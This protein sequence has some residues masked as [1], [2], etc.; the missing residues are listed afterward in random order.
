MKT[1]DY[2]SLVRDVSFE[3]LEQQG[4]LQLKASGYSMFPLFIPG[5]IITLNNIIQ[6]LK[7]GDIIAFKSKNRWIAHRIVSIDEQQQQL[8]TQGD[9]CAKEDAPIVITDVI[10]VVSAYYRN[11]KNMSE[12]L[13]KSGVPDET[14]KR[15]IAQKLNSLQRKKH[16]KKLLS[17]ISS[18]LKLIYKG[19]E[20]RLRFTAFLTLIIGALPLAGLY[21]SKFLINTLPDKSGESL[22]NETI[23]LLLI[24]SGIIIFLLLLQS[25]LSLVNQL[26]REKL[27]QSI[28]LHI[29]EIMHE[30]FA[31]INY[32]HIENTKEQN[33]IHRAVQESGYRPGKINDHFLLLIQSS[34]SWLLIA[35]ILI[36]IHWLI[37]VV[38]FI[39]LMPLLFSRLAHSKQQ[40]T[41]SVKE[42]KNEREIYYYHRIVTSLGFAKELRLFGMKD[43]FI[44]RF[45]NIQGSVFQRKNLLLKKQAVQEIFLQLASG[46]FVALA[47]FIAVYLTVIGKI[48]LGSFIVF[49]LL[50]QRGFA[51]LRDWLYSLAGIAEN[52]LYMK[53]FSAFL[54]LSGEEKNITV[55]E[56]ISDTAIKAQDVSFSYPGS[57]RKALNHISFEIPK[58]KKVAFVGTNGS[59]KTT[60]I[61]LICGFYNP[62]KG[63]IA[64]ND[65]IV[66]TSI[67]KEIQKQISVVFQDFALYNISARENIFLGKSTEKEVVDEIIEAAKKAGIHD[68]FEKLP[69]GYETLLGNLFEKSEELSIGQWQKIAIARALYRNAPVVLLDE[70][71]SAL[72]PFTE[73][74][75][76]ESLKT[77]AEQSTVIIVSHRLS[78]IK[79]TDCIYVFDDGRIVEQG[80]HEKLMANRGTYFQM[81]Q[82]QTE[83]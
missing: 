37:F 62:S 2:D 4:S 46:I 21:I 50:F 15:K 29:A 71:S 83:P 12:L 36:S 72:D 73:K 61:K 14:Q 1:N 17:G 13:V 78:S 28:R 59:G 3:M 67:S 8:I 54:N 45:K 57:I 31:T 76:L 38:L 64:V 53:D 5:D 60:L 24:I 68:V 79:W 80:T 69:Q 40:Y 33:L 47:F 6:P 35:V 77:L 26:F 25:V 44:S 9:S 55:S 75:M 16:L 42:S 63:T 18:D 43:F 7:V 48:N 32:E 56:N 51:V 81:Y 52:H 66:N 70:P 65:T 11:K 41:Q 82:S 30:K 34:F 58:G 22:T 39:S 27:S 74:Q 19:S 10:G 49:L 20:K 23:Q